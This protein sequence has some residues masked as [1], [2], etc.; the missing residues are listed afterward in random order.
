VDEIKRI[1]Q[2]MLDAGVPK[3]RIRSTMAR[4]CG[5]QP[6][7][8]HAWYQGATK[9]PSAEHLI[10]LAHFYGL[11]LQWVI[12][13]KGDKES[14]EVSSENEALILDLIRRIPENYQELAVRQLEL[15]ADTK[16]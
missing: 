15:L 12:T 8:V 7:S 13:G 14:R 11:S 16:K 10:A 3:R 9:R 5:L 4:I 2:V 6:Q 1:E